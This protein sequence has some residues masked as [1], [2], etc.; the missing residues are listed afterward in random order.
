[1]M[2]FN[3]NLIKCMMTPVDVKTYIRFSVNFVRSMVAT[4]NTVSL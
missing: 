1:M 3:F 2:N 4:M